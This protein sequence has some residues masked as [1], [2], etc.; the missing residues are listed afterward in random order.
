[1][2]VDVRQATRLEYPVVER[3]MELYEHDFS[4]FD[5]KDLGDDGLYRYLDL[6]SY[7]SDATQAAYVVTVDGKWAGFCLTSSEVRV[8]GSER[9]IDE[10]FVVRKYRRRG[11]G[12]QVATA[13]CEHT[14][15][16]W[17]VRIHIRNE[18]AA[19]FWRKV[20]AGYT[21]GAFHDVPL[22]DDPWHRAIFTFD[23]RRR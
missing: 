7:W 6:D 10:M 23:S 14:P 3:M 22:V 11:V 2:R 20:I 9:S 21:G 17:E 8:A 12:R 13:V 1:M 16:R 4:E 15:A 18:P 19:V 5:D